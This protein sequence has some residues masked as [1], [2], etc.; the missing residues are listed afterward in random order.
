M[1]REGFFQLTRGNRI[2]D[3]VTL[4]DNFAGSNFF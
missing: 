3:S 1:T 4:L 2:A